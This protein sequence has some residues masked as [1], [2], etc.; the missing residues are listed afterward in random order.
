MFICFNN[1]KT[2]T[3]NITEWMLSLWE[4]FWVQYSLLLLNGLLEKLVTL[5]P[6]ANY[7]VQ[8]LNLVLTIFVFFRSQS[9]TVRRM[10]SKSGSPPSRP[11]TVGSVRSQ[12]I[13]LPPIFGTSTPSFNAT[14]SAS[15][16][17]T[18][19]SPYHPTSTSTSGYSSLTTPI[20]RLGSS[21]L[22]TPRSLRLDSG[23]VPIK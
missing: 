17:G 16:F 12:P 2:W 8:S 3:S 7:Q 4:R 1:F 18:L 14:P 10:R 22:S 20:T 5:I 19:S 21:T 9:S 15:I 13:S 23:K 11:P 6:H